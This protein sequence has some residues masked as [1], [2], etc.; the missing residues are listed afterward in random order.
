MQK[1][2]QTEHLLAHPETPKE[3]EIYTEKSEVEPYKSDM[4]TSLVSRADNNKTYLDLKQGGSISFTSRIL[5]KG[6]D[7]GNVKIVT[8]RNFV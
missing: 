6:L 2:S 4:D 1:K 3:G 5:L 8:G 7:P